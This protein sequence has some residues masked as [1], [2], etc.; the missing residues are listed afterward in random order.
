M[1]KL[2]GGFHKSIRTKRKSIYISM[3]PDAIAILRKAALENCIYPG[4]Y[5]ERMLKEEIRKQ[6]SK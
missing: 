3:L 2:R 5:V 1:Q 6:E 4:E